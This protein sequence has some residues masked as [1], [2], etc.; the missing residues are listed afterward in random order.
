VFREN[1]LAESQT[2]LSIINNY[3][4]HLLFDFGEILCDGSEYNA[5]GH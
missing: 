2:S 4:P 5:I 1:W 3:F